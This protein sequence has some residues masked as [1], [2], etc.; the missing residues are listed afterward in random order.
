MKKSNYG[1]GRFIYTEWLW[2]IF[3]YF[4]TLRKNELVFEVVIPVIFSIVAGWLY[5]FKDLVDKALCFLAELLPT[6]IS[7]LI[8]FTIMMITL[9]LNCSGGNLDKLKNTKSERK[10]S[11]KP[12]SLFQ[13]LHIQFSHTLLLEV[14]LMLVVFFYYFING[15]GILKPIRVFILGFEVY[16]MLNI[17]LSILRGMTNIFFSFYKDEK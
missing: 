8:G 6:A 1:L 12:I 11:N 14:I 3:C 2:T 15:L 4:A 10:I 16:L 7:V 5:N 9:L 13:G 17:L